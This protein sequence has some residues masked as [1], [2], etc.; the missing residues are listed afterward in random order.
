MAR[1]DNRCPECGMKITTEFCIACRTRHWT[2]AAK[3][4]KKIVQASKERLR[5]TL[6]VINDPHEGQV[7]QW[8]DCG[9]WTESSSL[10]S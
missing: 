9:S 3:Q 10:K 5:E 4:D 7:D 6:G 2:R 8:I 1:V